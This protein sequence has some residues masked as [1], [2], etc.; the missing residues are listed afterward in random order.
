MKEL[1][2]Q[3]LTEDDGQGITE[4]ALILGLVVFG[5]WVLISTSGI[6]TSISTLFGNVKSEID[7]CAQGGQ[8]CGAGTK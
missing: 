7:K 3:L 1:L 8:G 4:Y 5:L 6:G 2:Y